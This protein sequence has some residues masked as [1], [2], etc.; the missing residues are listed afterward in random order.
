[1]LFRSLYYQDNNASE[2]ALYRRG[3]NLAPEFTVVDSGAR[4][5]QAMK[6]VGAYPDGAFNSSGVPVVAYKDQTDNDLLYAVLFADSSDWQINSQADMVDGVFGSFAA[7]VVTDT[8]QLV[9]GSFQ[10]DLESSK[11]LGSYV[12]VVQDFPLE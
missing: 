6:F 8:N 1:M 2:L 12:V 3:D 5:G 10:H 9:L 4:D 7:V 11:D